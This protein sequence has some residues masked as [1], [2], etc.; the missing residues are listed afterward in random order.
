[1]LEQILTLASWPIAVVVVCF[2]GMIIFRQPITRLIDRTR[3]VTKTGLEA[4][5]PPQDGKSDFKPSAPEE[6]QRLFD[7]SLLVP[8]E[9]EIRAEL[10]RL[11]LREQPKRET[12]LI[13]ILAVASIIL[14]F[15]RT[16]FSI[17]G[18]QLAILQFLN[19]LG[20]IGATVESLKPYYDLAKGQAPELYENYS[21]EQW[22]TFME[23]HRLVGRKESKVAITLVGREFLKYLVNQGFSLYKAG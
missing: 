13:Q 9:T 7:H 23:N 3:R 15:E 10:E 14:Q 1:M 4:D 19:P 22:L 6:L 20:E 16:Y 2:L 8:Q 18:S 11:A 21:F 12:F 5:A 17:W